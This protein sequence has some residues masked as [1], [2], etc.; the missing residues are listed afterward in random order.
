ME[1]KIMNE[2]ESLEFISQMISNTQQRF[3][4]HNAL[5]FLVFGYATVLVSVVVWCL[6]ST[7]HLP[8][9][10]L[11]WLSIP[12]IGYGAMRLL[13]SKSKRR[14]VTFVDKAIMYVWMVIGICMILMSLLTFFISIP[15]LFEVVLLMGIA[16]TL[17][18]L[19]AKLKI[20]TVA[21]ILSVLSSGLILFTVVEGVNIVLLFGAIFFVLMVIPGHILYSQKEEKYV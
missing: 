16:V 4:K 13:S 17:T 21:G 5:P 2:K 19:L 14:R 8:Q 11:L 15:I 3:Q 20:I 12:V 18:G 6:L 9:W 7:T 10:N 1:E